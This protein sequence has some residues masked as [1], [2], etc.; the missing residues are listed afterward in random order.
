[1][2]CPIHFKEDREAVLHALIRQYPLGAMVT[3]GVSGI[4]AEHI[5]FVLHEEGP[6]KAVLRGHVAR[7]NPVGNEGSVGLDSLVIFQGPQIYI[8]PSWY[9][10]KTE[11]GK[12]VPTWNYVLVHAHGKVRLMHDEEWLKRHL[13]ALTFS[14]ESTQP[15]PWEPADAPLKFLNTQ[16]KGIIGV[17]IEIDRLQG[18]WK[19]SQNKS[20]EDRA[21][22]I[23]GL[24]SLATDGANAM[25]DVA[26]RRV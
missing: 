6:G 16:I 18:K 7:S 13:K 9:P 15:N 11:H 2:H 14:Q 26:R 17:E 8:T 10:S 22:V 4:S 24:R 5:P 21:G 23:N 25:A 1:M 19:V 12:V 3:H 20:V